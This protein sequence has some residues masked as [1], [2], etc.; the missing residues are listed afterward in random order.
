M[1]YVEA[2]DAKE[3]AASS[4]TMRALVRKVSLVGTMIT[5]AACGLDLSVPGASATASDSG[6]ADATP[7]TDAR[8]TTD[9]AS[10]DTGLP[11][12][13][14][15]SVQVEVKEGS[16][17]KLG[18]GMAEPCSKGGP[19]VDLDIVNDTADPI[20][21]VDVTFDCRESPDGTIDP[22]ES[23]SRQTAERHRWRL[24]S[25]SGDLLLDFVV[26]RGPRVEIRLR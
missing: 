1:G 2:I 20:E 9:A 17:D 10:A 23:D 4:E 8:A 14:P 15:S 3:S 25:A 16:I 13:P 11:G 22:G 19:P 21:V 6:S 18:P 5:L 7:S 24:K 12:A 26:A